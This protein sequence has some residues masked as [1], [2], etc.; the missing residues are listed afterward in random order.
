LIVQINDRHRRVEI[1]ESQRG[2]VLG[3][4]SS[5]SEEFEVVT[6]GEKDVEEIHVDAA[7]GEKSEEGVAVLRKDKM[8]SNAPR[9]D[10]FLEVFGVRLLGGDT[11]ETDDGETRTVD[12][13][14]DSTFF[15]HDAAVIGF[16][17]E[18]L[19]VRI[20]EFDQETGA[21]DGFDVIFA[22]ASN[23][24]EG[25]REFV[26]IDTSRVAEGDEEEVHW[27]VVADG[28]PERRQGFGDLGELL[29][30]CSDGCCR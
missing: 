7:E 1:I 3:R 8:V 4:E 28:F 14:V 29:G 21:A 12:G 11:R 15:D 6:N 13:K 17:E 20:I 9:L 5:R 26:L 25:L 18:V 16:D 2:L 27:S 22:N 24:A 30:S 23:S 10:G 19:E